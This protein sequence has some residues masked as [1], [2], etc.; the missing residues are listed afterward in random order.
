MAEEAKVNPEAEAIAPKVEAPK[1]G[2]VEAEAAKVAPTVVV[3]DAK[4]PETVPLAQYLEIKK[5]LK[6]WKQKALEAE[7]KTEKTQVEIE[8]FAELA[9]KYPD[10]NGEFLKDLLSFSNRT[11]TK[12]LD[13]VIEQQ[14]AE[15]KQLAFDKAFD[16]LFDKTLADNPDLP[17]TIDK[18]LIKDLASSPKYRTTPLAEILQ[19]MYPNTN[20]GKASS[21]NDMRSAADKVDDIVSFDKITPDQKKAIMADPSARQKYFNWLDK[22]P[23]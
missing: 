19:K 12:K 3:P 9:Q 16:N 11:A 23:G 8:G 5:D 10:V 2:T 4:V 7:T 14:E 22:Q 17:K 1:E 15:R 21:E 18:A 20:A 6:E 13:S